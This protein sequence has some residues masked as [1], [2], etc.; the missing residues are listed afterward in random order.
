VNDEMLVTPPASAFTEVARELL[1]DSPAH[2]VAHSERS[3]Q[4]AA[5]VADA[6][7]VDLGDIDHEAL[8]L[9]V[10]LHDIGLAPS[11][12]GD[13]RFEVR[14]ANRARTAL[15]TAGLEADRAETVW[16]VIALHATTAI[17]GNKSIEARL[18]NRG[19][20]ID[21]RGVTGGSL[22]PERIRAV[23]DR[24]PRARFP[25]DFAATLIAEV[26]AHPSTARFSWMESIAAG[27][28]PDYRPI[29]FL[30]ALAASADFA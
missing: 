27:H 30:E 11:S 2:V 29:D 12:A 1:A 25:A 19:I 3:Y 16:D 17:A 28:V 9:G 21:V 8:Y 15:R 7:G 14:G 10:L 6:E 23:L 20:S 22:A 24:W 26:Q 4:F 13:D 5:L 18:A